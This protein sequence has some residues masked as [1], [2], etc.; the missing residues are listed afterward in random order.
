MKNKK[1][2]LVT[3]VGGNVGQGVIMNLRSR[4]SDID[5]YGTDVNKISAGL[6]FCDYSLQ[7][8][9][10]RD[11]DYMSFMLNYVKNE[12]I[13]LII[14]TTDDEVLA[15]SKSEGKEI[16]LTSPYDS[17]KVF[18]DKWENFLAF[19]KMEI[20]F[21]KSLLPSQWNGDFESY[22]VKP[23]DGRGSRDIFASPQNVNAFSD[24]FLVQ[25]YL[26]GK[27][28]SISFYVD[29]SGNLID[30][31]VF[32]RELSHGMTSLCQVVED[33]SLEIESLIRKIIQH[34][35]IRG[36]CNLQGRVTTKG[37]IIFEVNCRYSGTN[38]IRSEFGFPDVY[39][40]CNEYLYN[41][42]PEKGNI[43]KGAAMRFYSDIIYPDIKLE[44]IAPQN[45]KAFI[46][47]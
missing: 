17:C 6:F 29:K 25:E 38:S 42:P 10:A 26:E 15:F 3:G 33:Y 2:V 24:E 11:A 45:K 12:K 1:K 22:I 41:Y 23:R 8:P 7:V 44:Q 46:K 40:G 19:K 36:P 14:P 16:A 31:I 18:H 39:W 30:F 21:A 34:F 27:E 32:E 9:L 4:F 43:T 20:P 5:I 13:D 35:T 37:I 47:P 28:V